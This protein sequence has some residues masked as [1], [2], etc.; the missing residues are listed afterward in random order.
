MIKKKIV[1]TI[2]FCL[3]TINFISF[4]QENKTNSIAYFD[5]YFG[6]SSVGTF[7]FGY[8]FNYQKKNNLF[9]FRNIY[10]NKFHD[11]DNGPNFTTKEQV[12]NYYYEYSLLSG[13]RYTLDKNS[14]SF[15][16]GLSY[17]NVGYFLKNAPFS[18]KENFLGFPFEI[19]VK[20]FKNKKKPFG[21]FDGLI[22]IGKPTGFSN[23]IGFK[24]YGNLSKE[25]YLGL[26]LT[27]GL[28]WHKKY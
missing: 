20:F 7:D 14:Y 26:G 15:L 12:I 27:F 24:L 21:L 19:G 5:T 8:S 11:F 9:L 16:I 28:G 23:S 10:S 13:K 6:T 3:L 18:S 1:F 22:S 25:S 2:F 17:N 4:S